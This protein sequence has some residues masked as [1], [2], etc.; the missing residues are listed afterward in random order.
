MSASFQI[1]CRGR[2]ERREKVLKDPVRVEVTVSQSPGSNMIG[3]T[4]KC[5]YNTGGHGDRCKASHPDRDKVGD[6]ISCPYAVD[7]PYAVDNKYESRT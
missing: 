6:G 2:N 4:V 5:P 1:E 3:S 7:L